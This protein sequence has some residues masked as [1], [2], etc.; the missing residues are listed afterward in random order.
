MKR[1]TRIVSSFHCKHVS[2]P[3]PRTG[4]SLVVDRSVAQA[5]VNTVDV[6]DE[7][8]DSTLK[9]DRL[10]EGRL[11]DL[12]ENDFAPPLGVAF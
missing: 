5:T 10:G 8:R 6:A 2:K 3:S 11:G 4:C 1:R 9:F 12:N 7:L